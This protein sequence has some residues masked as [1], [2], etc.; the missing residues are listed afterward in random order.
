[1]LTVKK[2]RDTNGNNILLILIILLRI[3]RLDPIEVPVMNK[4]SSRDRGSLLILYNLETTYERGKYT[5]YRVLFQRKYY[6]L[7]Y[8]LYGPYK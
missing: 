5:N 2:I 7:V 6:W 3:L 4:Y 1:M 8:H